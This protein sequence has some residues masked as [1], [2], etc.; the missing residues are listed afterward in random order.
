MTLGD[1]PWR[2]TRKKALLM[3]TATVCLAACGSTSAPTVAPLKIYDPTG[4]ETT[5][6]TSADLVKRSVRAGRDLGFVYLSLPLTHEGAR[7]FQRLTRAIAL[8]GR[9]VH[10]MQAIVVEIGGRW[11]RRIGVDYRDFPNGITHA[12]KNGLEISGLTLANARRFA[13]LLTGR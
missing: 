13:R 5:Q 9:R 8:R 12:D 10:S 4:K 2:V 11:H 3:L 1:T 6:V 7:K